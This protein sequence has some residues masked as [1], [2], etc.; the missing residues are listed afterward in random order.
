[1]LINHP[2][3]TVHRSHFHRRSLRSWLPCPHLPVL[4][5][6]PTLTRVARATMSRLNLKEIFSIRLNPSLPLQDPFKRRVYS[7]KSMPSRAL[8]RMSPHQLVTTQ[9]TTAFVRKR[10]IRVMNCRY[11]NRVR[12]GVLRWIC[13]LRFPNRLRLPIIVC[14][15]VADLPC[16]K[17]EM[18]T[19]YSLCARR[20]IHRVRPY[21]SSQKFLSHVCCAIGWP[22]LSTHT[23]HGK[24]P[25]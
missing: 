18:R 21:Y 7:V 14:D 19:T 12:D 3:K 25:W 1:M 11:L 9:I 2:Q 8:N 4:V 24:G 16:H 13:Q 6:L 10:M 23:L 15:D 5:P 22:S 20:V 17:R